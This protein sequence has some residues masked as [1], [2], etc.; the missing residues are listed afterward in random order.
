M[1]CN[2]ILKTVPIHPES[3]IACWQ[4]AEKQVEVR[5]ALGVQVEGTAQVVGFERWAR[6]R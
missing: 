6:A 2:S 4:C 1:L 5:L 3:A